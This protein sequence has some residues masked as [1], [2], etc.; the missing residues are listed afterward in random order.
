MA[1]DAKPEE[2]STDNLVHGYGLENVKTI[3]ET[4]HGMCSTIV[5]E[6]YDVYVVIPIIDESKRRH[7]I[8]YK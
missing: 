3:S 7:G 2:D 4:Y 5:K 1:S 8:Q 6:A